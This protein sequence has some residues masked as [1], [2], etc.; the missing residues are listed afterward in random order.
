MTT[1]LLA[2]LFGLFG[3]P[4]L[5]LAMGHAYRRRS[6]RSR[7]AFW[8]GVVGY[9]GGAVLMAVAMY[10]PPVAWTDGS[11]LRAIG[12]HWTMLGGSVLGMGLGA[13]LGA[14]GTAG[15]A[16]GTAGEE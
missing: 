5:L 11:T 7:M 15:N 12:V 2:L 1:D 16:R 4:I 13:A 14:Q 6:S 9:T 10:L 8:G 3:P